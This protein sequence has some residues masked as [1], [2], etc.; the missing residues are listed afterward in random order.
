MDFGEIIFD[1]P[2]N[3][4]TSREYKDAQKKLAAQYNYRFDSSEK[5]VLKPL[6]ERDFVF[7]TSENPDLITVSSEE[8]VHGIIIQVVE[9][10]QLY[11][12]LTAEKREYYIYK[13]IT[14][15]IVSTNIEQQPTKCILYPWLRYILQRNETINNIELVIQQYLDLLFNPINEIFLDP[16]N[17]SSAEYDAFQHN[18]DDLYTRKVLLLTSFLIL[19]WNKGVT[20][21]EI[22]KMIEEL[23]STDTVPDISD[24]IYTLPRKIY[25]IN[26]L[27]IELVLIHVFTNDLKHSVIFIDNIFDGLEKIRSECSDLDKVSTF[28]DSRLVHEYLKDSHII[29][30]IDPFLGLDDDTIQPSLESYVD[31]I[32]RL[33][34]ENIYLQSDG[35][36]DFNTLYNNIQTIPS[37]INISGVLDPS[38][39]Y[40]I[41]IAKA[42][43]FILVNRKKILDDIF[44]GS[45]SPDTLVLATYIEKIWDVLYDL[46]ILNISHPFSEHQSLI[47]FGPVYQYT[48]FFAKALNETNIEED[49]DW[50]NKLTVPD[51]I[52]M[53][54]ELHPYNPAQPA[55]K[56]IIFAL[57]KM[58]DIENQFKIAHAQHTPWSPQLQKKYHDLQHLNSLLV[59]LGVPIPK[60][61]FEDFQAKF[62]FDTTYTHFNIIVDQLIYLVDTIQDYKDVFQ[63]INDADADAYER[64]IDVCE[65]VSVTLKLFYQNIFKDSGEFY[66]IY[67]NL[68]NRQKALLIRRWKNII[69][70]V[71][72]F[73]KNIDSR[74]NTSSSPS[75]PL[76]IDIKEHYDVGLKELLNNI[77][78]I[79]NLGLD[80]H[81]A[82]FDVNRS[83]SVLSERLGLYTLRDYR[84]LQSLMHP[85]K[86]ILDRMDQDEFHRLEEQGVFGD[87]WAC[88]T[89][90]TNWIQQQDDNQ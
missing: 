8:F 54:K 90:C 58:F 68:Y 2:I 84:K 59:D 55:H 20:E 78:R 29:K 79:Y 48:D 32:L 65:N 49:W 24:Y 83:C 76:I 66:N 88:L 39:T 87:V 56:Y 60:R 19:M 82:G 23:K 73:C 70:L 62:H 25:N 33:F 28:P 64:K 13:Q 10:I 74:S 6:R 81:K 63:S 22:G 15:Y 1:K 71:E 26:E 50:I 7:Y 69:K 41:D 85:D 9:D 51:I 67:V 80:C 18:V 89:I 16:D 14:R 57:A 36:P 40:H 35:M 11:D 46:R 5:L 4:M 53:L 12:S 3:Q 45:I 52:L 61:Y 43:G 38:N 31:T 75:R 34:P 72:S 42:L 37:S 21:S 44:I 47:L 86:H 30:N 17:F 27:I 77:Q